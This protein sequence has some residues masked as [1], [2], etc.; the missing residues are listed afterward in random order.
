MMVMVSGT[1]G[2]KLHL[3]EFSCWQKDRHLGMGN[4]ECT[5]CSKEHGCFCRIIFTGVQ[6][7]NFLW[8]VN[9]SVK[10]FHL[11]LSAFGHFIAG[12][13]PGDVVALRPS[14]GS[15]FR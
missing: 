10:P 14:I 5:L 3:F 12:K 6:S 4:N 11:Q 7:S 2:G 15:S 8:R 1:E 9:R 13:H